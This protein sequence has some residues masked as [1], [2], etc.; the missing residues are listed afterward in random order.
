MELK[1]TI[2]KNIVVNKNKKIKVI[3]GG[4]NFLFKNK[5]KKKHPMVNKFSSN[6]SS[7]F[8]QNSNQSKT[9]N[10]TPRVVALYQRYILSGYNTRGH[11]ILTSMSYASTRPNNTSEKSNPDHLQYEFTPKNTNIKVT[12]KLEYLND[13]TTVEIEKWIGEFRATA[14]VCQWDETT[15]KEI[16]FAIVD[17]KYHEVMQSKTSID[18]MLDSIVKT[19]YPSNLLNHFFHELSAVKQRNF[20]FIKQFEVKIIRC[21]SKIALCQP[22]SPK[23]IERKIDESF[24]LGLTTETLVENAKAKLNTRKEIIDHI[25]NIE[26]ILIDAEENNIKIKERTSGHNETQKTNTFRTKSKYCHYHKT[27]THDSKECFALQK[28][29]SAET[30]DKNN[31]IKEPE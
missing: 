8:S 7:S 15:T 30:T 10:T 11:D 28:R 16:L 20:L 6:K 23:E 12:K 27:T 29:K 19:I 18:A 13:N 2:L 9:R 3:F 1:K 4:S 31:F 24:Q 25:T 5:K 21:V 14:R 17:T 26:R 22:M